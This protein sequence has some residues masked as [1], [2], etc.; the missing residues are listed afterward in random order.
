MIRAAIIA[1]GDGIRLKE[2]AM[3]KPLAV[4]AGKPLIHWVVEGLRFAGAKKITV[5]TNSRGGA[6]ATSL[7]A[8][9]PG[10]DFDF[11]TA[12][13]ASSFESFRL[14]ALRMAESDEDF[15][16]STTD[17]LIKHEDMAKF[18]L[19][20]RASRAE[21]GLALTTF[22]DDEKPLWADLDEVG[23]VRGLGSDAKTRRF[24]TCGLYYM[25]RAA[26]SRLPAAAAH[27]RLRDYLSTLAAEA[28]VAGVVLSKS[29]DVDR[30][31]DLAAAESFLTTET[32]S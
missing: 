24:V 18:V 28:R 30:P 3:L 7:K 13:T 21:A 31:A 15:V 17:A 29:L 26:A 5:L 14:V 2:S 32:K 22:V 11:V 6:V 10:T 12:D 9:Y 1:A 23:L 4:V 19:E 25:T 16:I 27:G 20:C 8:T